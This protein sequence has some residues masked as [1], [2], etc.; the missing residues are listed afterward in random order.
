MKYTAPLYQA[1]LQH[2]KEGSV[3][4]HM[5]VHT[6]D[7]PLAAAFGEQAL[8]FD[9][10]EL[11]KTDNLACPHG[12][13]A[14]AHDA[15]AKAYHCCFA[16]FLV[17]G[18]TAGIHSMLL[19]AC[20]RG[21][22]VLVDRC[23]HVS[24]LNAC[25]MYGIQ[26]QFIERFVLPD[27]QMV[28]PLS[29]AQVQEAIYR[30]PTAKAVLIT[31]PTYYGVNSDLRSIADVVHRHGLLLLADAAHGSHYAFCSS[32]PESA[33]EAG[34]D[35]CAV[36]LHKTLGALTQTALL[37]ANGPRIAAARLKTILNMVQTTSPS[38]LLMASADL[39]L[40]DM[41]A[42]GEEILSRAARLV[43]DAVH[44]LEKATS[45]S[46]L[47]SPSLSC[48]PLRLTIG[49]SFYSIT[50]YALAQSLL[51]GYGI[52]VEMADMHHIVCIV[53]PYIK[54]GAM[55]RLT[56]ALIEISRTPS[57]ASRTT[58]TPQLPPLL[59][60]LPPEQAFRSEI[61]YLPLKHCARKIAA[62]NI[63][64]YPPGVPI[65]VWGSELTE[66]ACDYLACYL[67]SGGQATG[68]RE[69]GWVPVIATSCL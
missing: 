65:A 7:G 16:H 27:G 41:C 14:Q 69:D 52:E 28:A 23:A 2:A 47:P 11:E 60:R 5:P 29:A 48:D 22:T 37:L 30:C 32:Y 38:Y 50:G 1:L 20:Q 10:T 21:D 13:I 61:E 33:I 9:T 3:P 26:P 57:P 49:C 6:P 40:K 54:E 4:F 8:A 53:S 25:A 34:A 39:A 46:C 63:C 62:A 12:C 58:L 17:G 56:E 31:T 55:A 43:A 35:L 15:A 24:V 18:S 36:S 59:L 44:R 51:D 67:S 19:Y 45:F 66:Q 64:I 42:H 68:L